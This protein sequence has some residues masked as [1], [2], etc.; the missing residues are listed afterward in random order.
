MKQCGILALLALWVCPVIQAGAQS[1]EELKEQVKSLQQRVA[2]LESKMGSDSYRQRQAELVQKLVNEQQQKNGSGDVV[3]VTAGFR[4]G[5]FFI[6]SAD[7]DFSLEFNT[8]LQIRHYYAKTDDGKS[9][10][11]ADGTP[12]AGGNGLDSS[13]TGLEFERARLYLSG[14]VLKDLD[15]DIAFSGGDDDVT[16]GGNGGTVRVYEYNL[17]REFSPEFGLKIGRFKSPFGKQETTSSGRQSLVDRSLANEVFNIG[18]GQGIEAFGLVKAGSQPVHYRVGVFQGLQDDNEIN[19]KDHDNSPAFTARLAMPLGNAKISDFKDESDLARVKDP[20]SMIGTS[21]AWSNDRAENNFTGGESD[22]YEF[23]G[24]STVDGRT[25][26]FELGGEMFL[27]GL[28]YSYKHNGLSL[29]LEGFVQCIDVDSGAVSD[30]SDFGNTVRSGLDGEK[31]TNYGWH[32]QSGYFVAKN[33]ELV[34][35]VSGVCVDSS[36]DSYEYAGGWNWYLSGQDL[37]LSMDITYID[38]LPLESSS[39]QFEGIQNNS[40]FLVRTQLQFQF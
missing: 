1:Q 35:R 2:E 13:A 21:F 20:V 12:A 32:A 15:Y 10:L 17:S 36:N 23:L 40:L 11:N 14:H 29:N 9:S 38:D 7:G 28:D 26:I 4:K 6:D 3:P 5:K 25:D 19:A 18:R 24:K 22:S 31:L 27:G 34:G 33:F 8:R 30:E 39:P 37:K 16:D